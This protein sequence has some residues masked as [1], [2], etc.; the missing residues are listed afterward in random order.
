[1]TPCHCPRCGFDLASPPFDPARLVARL[2]DSFAGEPFTVAMVFRQAERDPHLRAALAG[3]SAKKIGKVLQR[4]AA[5]RR[6]YDGL[7]IIRHPAMEA[8]AAVWAVVLGE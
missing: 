8:G 3:K 2:A 4:I 5:K 7:T 6:A 1:M